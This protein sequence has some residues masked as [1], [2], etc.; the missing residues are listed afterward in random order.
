MSEK[1]TEKDAAAQQRERGG[2]DAKTTREARLAA[3][4]RDNL[5]R[6]KQQAHAR[7]S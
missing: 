1:K 4:L 5:K 6:R 3:A 7:K 2:K